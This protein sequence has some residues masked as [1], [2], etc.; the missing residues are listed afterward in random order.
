MRQNLEMA[1][2]SL[3]FH[4]ER[5]SFH[6]NV[7]KD[8]L[9]IAGMTIVDLT[10]YLYIRDAHVTHSRRVPTHMARYLLLFHIERSSF[11]QN[12]QKDKLFY[13]GMLYCDLTHYLYT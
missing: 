10:H 4:L 13:A 7:Q 5:S 8:K 3:L 11:H 2:S 12:V 1:L 9:Y 6:Q